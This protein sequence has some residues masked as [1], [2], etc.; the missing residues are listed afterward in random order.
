MLC[1]IR[2][3]GDYMLGIAGFA[4]G[5]F[6]AWLSFKMFGWSKEGEKQIEQIVKDRK[7]E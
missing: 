6:T 1:I 5:F 3:I 4:V 2:N 7:I